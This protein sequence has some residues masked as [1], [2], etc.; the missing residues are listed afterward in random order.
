MSETP[1]S[2]LI[3]AF[4]S[5]Q[6][7]EALRA[8]HTALLS[9]DLGVKVRGVPAGTVGTYRVAAGDDVRMVQVATPDGRIMLKACA[10]P[11]AFAQRYD[12]AINATI[13]GR[14]LL[15]MVREAPGVEGVLVC[16]AASLH[17]I[18]IGRAEI[19]ALLSPE[20]ASPRRPWWRVW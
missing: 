3:S 18:P 9:A 4:V 11:R 7:P 13:T 6:R 8:F 16:S 19:H 17:S 1:L 15:E 20:P 14:R 2:D 5:D 10:D 12:A